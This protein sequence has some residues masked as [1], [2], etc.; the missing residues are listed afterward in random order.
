M[1]QDIEIM[2]D[3]ASIISHFRLGFW[4]SLPFQRTTDARLEG[5]FYRIPTEVYCSSIT[6]VLAQNLRIS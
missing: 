5:K 1:E 2:Y 4:K 6:P 3:K